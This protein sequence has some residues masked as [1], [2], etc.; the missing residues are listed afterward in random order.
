MKSTSSKDNQPIPDKDT[1]N[2]LLELGAVNAKVV[3][4]GEHPLVFLP[5]GT[6]VTS[7][8]KYF[9]PKRI[10]QEVLLLEAGSFIEYVN[11]FKTKDTLIFANVTETSASFSA[12]LDYHSAD[13]QA[14]TQ[15][16]PAFCAHRAR[17]DT[18]MTPEW[19]TWVGSNRKPM[20][21]VEFATFLEDNQNL[22][23]QP[24]GA[25][26]LELV[27]NLTGKQD[28]RFTS[29][30]RLDSG[31]NKFHYDE[32][33][34]LRGSTAGGGTK[35]GDMDMPTSLKVGI[36]PFQGAPKYEV[37]ARIKYRIQERKLTL[38][39]ETIDMPG[40]V[41]D[42]IMLIVKQ[43]ADKTKIVPM[44]GSIGGTA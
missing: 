14:G 8:E 34:T 26:L 28:V 11:M 5:A 19:K 33:V 2:R 24:A 20:N 10:K 4:T 29:A 9:P 32:D 13:V 27:L 15:G 44:L 39:Y 17:L 35:P 3:E 1:L 6:N 30:E 7:L 31:K 16:N 22:F 21:Q 41:R 42:S 23:K 43:I 25:T 38:W 12:V 18:I 36:A 40:I 37:N